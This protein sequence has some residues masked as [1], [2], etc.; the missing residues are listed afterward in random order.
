M[1]FPSSLSAPNQTTKRGGGTFQ[2]YL[3]VH[4]P[5]IQLQ[6]HPSAGASENVSG[7]IVFSSVLSGAYTNVLLGMTVIIS[8]T[9]DYA[10]DLRNQPEN[11]FVTYVRL[12]ATS[13]VLSIGATKFQYVTSDYVTVLNDYR[14]FERK[15]RCIS[16]NDIRRD[17]DIQYRKP[18][19]RITGIYS[20]V[21]FAAPTVGTV[22]FTPSAAVMGASGSISTWAWDVDDGTITVGS[23]STQNITAT[24][25]IGSRYVHLTVTDSNGI[26]NYLTALI[27]VLPT[28]LSSVI[29]LDNKDFSISKSLESGDSASFT[30]L[31]DGDW[32]DGSQAIVATYAAYADTSTALTVSMVGWLKDIS[33]SL[34]GDEEVGF[35]NQASATI[36]GIS[37]YASQIQS[38][39]FYTELKTSPAVWGEFGLL[40][41]YHA[42]W[43]LV[44]EHSTLANVAAFDYPSDYADYKHPAINIPNGTILDVMGD[45]SFR[46]MGGTPNYS[47]NGEIV[48][49][50]SLPYMTS[51]SD[52]NAA[53]TYASYTTEDG[54]SADYNRINNAEIKAVDQVLMGCASYNTDF[55]IPLVIFAKAPAGDTSGYLIEELDSIIMPANT[56]NVLE[57]AGKLAA[58]HYFAINE[59]P[60]LSFVFLDG[61]HTL[62]PNC[63]Q[64]HKF[65]I[66]SSDMVSTASLSTSER[67]ICTD[68]Q[69]AYND[70]LGQVAVTATFRKETDGG[71][72]YLQEAGY[73]PT[74]QPNTQ[75]ALPQFVPQ[76]F[77]DTGVTNED[78]YDSENN[79]ESGTSGVQDPTLPP[80]QAGQAQG[81]GSNVLETLL[82]PMFNSTAVFSQASLTLGASYLLRITGDGKIATERKRL[83]F[84][85]TLGSE[86]GW[87]PNNLTSG[88]TS[89]R[90]VWLGNGWGRAF[91]SGDNVIVIET[92][93]T[94]PDDFVITES[95]YH[96]R[97]RVGS[98][99]R[100][101][102]GLPYTN[103]V[104]NCTDFVSDGLLTTASI[105][106]GTRTGLGIE[107]SVFTPPAGTMLL[108]RA[109]FDFTGDAPSTSGTIV[110][111]GSFRGDA[112]YWKY[113]DSDVEAY[114][115]T[116]G[117]FI[118]GLEPT[119][120][121]YSAAH[122]YEIPFTGEGGTVPFQ[123][124]D[125]ESNYSDNDNVYIKVEII[126]L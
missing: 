64:W 52:R 36:Q 80:S 125:P 68:V 65:T 96:I 102:Y 29:H 104:F 3:I 40:T 90:A 57:S 11:C 117:L 69:I 79:N 55:E 74:N 77:L 43:Y 111:L 89:D 16:A 88:D 67:F 103:G 32:L 7:Q 26:S 33:D 31:A 75:P 10:A 121:A 62:E 76:P 46:A 50:K 56:A 85:W 30:A 47:P 58:N 81:Q 120:P 54:L 51:D 22:A 24:F 71:D 86:L 35:V 25:P 115:S 20:T 41:T 124:F 66:A 99:F 18:K 72:N 110:D 60:T 14:V 91:V 126:A 84:D 12:A 48:F 105:D 34:A 13:T 38:E 122:S 92:A 15:L 23:S 63:F 39:G 2:R 27:V 106:E 8:P 82:V 6:F 5:S 116:T 59:N 113:N 83:I 107:F 114:P 73:V 112:F 119:A 93:F 21:V 4:T 94:W 123:Y 118:N 78:I 97:N 9:S 100:I 19:P 42:L 37:Y 44:S 95:R 108:Y 101:I 45:L 87:E 98:L 61:Y 53:D 17:W 49:R 1:P 70:E 109:E 28:N